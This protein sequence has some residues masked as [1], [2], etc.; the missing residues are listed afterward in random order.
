MFLVGL[1]SLLLCFYIL[2]NCE[3]TQKYSYKGLVNSRL[4][5]T[6]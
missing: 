2:P 4:L 3:Q 5:Q 1:L 6:K